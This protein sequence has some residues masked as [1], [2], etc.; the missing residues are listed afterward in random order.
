MTIHTPDLAFRSLDT[1]WNRERW[2][3]LPADGKRYEVIEGVLSATS[4]PSA[5]HQWIIR[6]L[7]L[8][9]L[10]PAIDQTGVGVTLWAPIGVFMPPCDP[11]QPDLLVVR[12]EDLGIIHDQRIFG[13]P[14]LIVE[15]L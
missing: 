14:A 13:V 15:V 3:A 1:G 12:T 5:F 2:E 8:Y 10:A 9:V 6:Q 4:T 7:V 11:V